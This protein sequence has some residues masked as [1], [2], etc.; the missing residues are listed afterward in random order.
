MEFDLDMDYP[1][2]NVTQIWVTLMEFDLDM[3]YPW[4]NVT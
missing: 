2:E 4:E 1:W 3:D